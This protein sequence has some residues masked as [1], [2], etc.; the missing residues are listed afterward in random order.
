MAG[1][2]D[3]TLIVAVAWAIGGF[4]VKL[5]YDRV[6]ES[7]KAVVGLSAKRRER[8]YD[9]QATVVAGMYERLGCFAVS[10]FVFGSSKPLRGRE[11]LARSH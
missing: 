10:A 6:A 2:S 7:H 4:I 11:I 5:L 8:F 3:Q 1:T 9:K